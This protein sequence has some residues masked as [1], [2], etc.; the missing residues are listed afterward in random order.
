M[1]QGGVLGGQYERGSRWT[2][3]E[4]SR[5]G[6]GSSEMEQRQRWMVIILDQ[7]VDDEWETDAMTGL[8]G[9]P[10]AGLIPLPS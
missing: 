4:R 10:A 6:E 1:D 3:M 9:V 2:A 8:L 5:H 7:R